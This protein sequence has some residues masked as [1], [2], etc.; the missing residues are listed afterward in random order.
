MN[1][2]VALSGGKDSTCL[3]LLLRDREPGDY[4]YLFTPA[5]NEPPELFAHVA[6]LEA[7]L[8][9]PVVRVG[10][11]GD[12]LL[13][14]I[15]GY[16]ALPNHR[17]RWCTRQLKVEP[18]IAWLRAHAPLTYFVGLR[19]DEPADERAGI[20]GEIPGVVQRFPL[21]E[22]GMGEADVWA[23][24]AARGVSVPRRTG[25]DWCYG[26]TLGEWYR[27]YRDRPD[28]YAE[29]EALEAATGHTFR[30]P[31]R[32]TW[33]A[34]LKELRVEFDRR[35]PR[36]ERRPG[37]IQLDLFD[38]GEVEHQPCRACTL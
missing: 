21:R 30:S 20:T 7:R 22:W 34:P 23:E 37:S 28:R 11:D 17:M 16:N 9:K 10:R 35:L 25:C 31:A 2:V 1:R 5:G 32:D 13:G 15:R 3:A 36:G 19:A 8:G 26:Q 12:G 27:L 38:S 29:A 33:S 4:E 14:L 24:L 18:A 6:R